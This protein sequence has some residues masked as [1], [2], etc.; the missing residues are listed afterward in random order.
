[1]T[2]GLK[3]WWQDPPDLRFEARLAGDSSNPA[4]VIC[5]VLDAEQTTYWGAGLWWFVTF[6]VEVMFVQRTG[7]DSLLLFDEPATPLHPSA[8][9]LVAKLLD[10]LSRSYQVIYTTHSP[11]MIDWNFPQRVR[12]FLRDHS[13]KRTSIINKPYDPRERGHDVW[14][15]L[16]E[17]IGVTLGDVGILNKQNVLVEGI[18]DQILLANAS[19]ALH[20]KGRGS[21]DL[22]QI[23]IIPH[24]DTRTLERL[25]SM[26]KSR[27]LNVVVLGDNDEQG[28]ATERICR[29]EQVPWIGIGQFCDRADGDKSTEDLVG[30]GDYLA[31]TNAFYDSFQWFSPMDRTSVERDIGEQSL[32]KYLIEFFNRTFPSES[33]SK[34]SVA[35]WLAQDF[36]SQGEGILG[37]FHALI[38][39]IK[40]D[41]RV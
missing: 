33:F 36:A 34:T 4:I 27:G 10:S 40:N 18:S 22:S 32:G 16:R 8:Q 6:L 37:R 25:I 30:I 11:F 23:S 13:S 3:T 17:S 41:M 15:P 24:R 21:L 31:A 19:A 38:E 9:R 2:E 1:V 20:H 7:R 35:I 5:N 26:I 12:L 39:R 14:D 28:K 29:Q